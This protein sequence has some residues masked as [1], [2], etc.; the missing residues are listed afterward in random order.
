MNNFSLIKCAQI[1]ALGTRK[2]GVENVGSNVSIHISTVGHFGE[3][4]EYR[5]SMSGF[6]FQNKDIIYI[7]LL[8]IKHSYVSCSGIQILTFAHS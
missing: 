2:L 6:P 3:T 8:N 5:L 1:P 4:H 7:L